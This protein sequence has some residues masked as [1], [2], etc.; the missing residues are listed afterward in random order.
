MP[1]IVQGVL[2]PRFYVFKQIIVYRRIRTNFSLGCIQHWWTWGY[3]EEVRVGFLLVGHMHFDIDQRFSSIS[4]V[5]K[6]DDINS[7]S[8]L[9]RWTCLICT[10]D[11]KHLGLEKLHYTTLAIQ[12]K[13][14]VHRNEWTTPL[15]ILPIEQLIIHAVQNICKWCMGAENGWPSLGKCS[16]LEKQTRVCQSLLGKHGGSCSFIFLYQLEGMAIG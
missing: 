2:Y 6:G 8:E 4:H 14:K 13:C 1:Y 10:A 16:K 3:F 5:L 9:L 12:Q 7:L 11:G 15:P